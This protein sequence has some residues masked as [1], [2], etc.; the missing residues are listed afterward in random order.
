MAE[1]DPIVRDDVTRMYDAQLAAYG[2]RHMIEK[3]EAG[4]RGAMIGIVIAIAVLGAIRGWSY[5]RGW[6]RR[7]RA[8]SP[9]P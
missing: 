7:D 9:R 2:E 6:Y 1:A 4:L 3:H 5:G 8:S